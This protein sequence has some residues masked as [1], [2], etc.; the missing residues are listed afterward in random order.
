MWRT[1]NGHLTDLSKI[2]NIEK[3][4][5]QDLRFD[6]SGNS[7]YINW[8]FNSEKERNTMLEKLKKLL[9]AEDVKW[10]QLKRLK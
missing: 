4:G 3:V 10:E 7:R 5:D 2:Y 8:H 6:A 1:Y 9:Q